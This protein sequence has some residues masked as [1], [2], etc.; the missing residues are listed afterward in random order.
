MKQG[1]SDLQHFPLHTVQVAFGNIV[2]LSSLKLVY[3]WPSMV[4]VCNRFTSLTDKC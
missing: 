1:N 4:P 3:Q 2:A